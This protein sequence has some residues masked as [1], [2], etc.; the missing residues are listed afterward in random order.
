MFVF[1][2]KNKILLCGVVNIWFEM[3]I[4]GKFQIE[5]NSLTCEF[6]VQAVPTSTEIGTP[7]PSSVQDIQCLCFK[8][9]IILYGVVNI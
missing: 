7:R 5:T 3:I 6:V 1:S 8:N 4:Q 2:A 9:K